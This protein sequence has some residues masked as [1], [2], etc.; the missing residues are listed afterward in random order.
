MKTYKIGI[1]GAG[2][3]NSTMLD[4]YTAPF[5]GKVQELSKACHTLGGTPQKIWRGGPKIGQDT[6]VILK[7]LAG[8]GDPEM[9]ALK[10]KGIID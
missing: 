9:A 3:S 1:I 4:R 5:T 10:E 6:E 7:T 8:L 2:H